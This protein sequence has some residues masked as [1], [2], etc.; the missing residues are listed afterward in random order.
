MLRIKKD[1]SATLSLI[2]AYVALAVV[3][4]VA[5][6]IPFLNKFLYDHFFIGKLNDGGIIAF[7]ILFYLALIPVT[8][9]D[10]LLIR[11]LGNVRRAEVFTSSAVSKLRGISWCCFA[12]CLILLCGGIGFYKLFIL[13]HAFLIVAVVAAF[14]GIVLRVVKNVIE[15]ATAIK[16]ENDFTI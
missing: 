13:P 5:V 3:A 9:A 14:L 16:S 7:V 1:S 8:T 6:A 11:L 10:I 2:L 4:A 12:E 15:E